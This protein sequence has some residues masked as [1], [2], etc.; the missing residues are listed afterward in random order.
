MKRQSAWCV[1]LRPLAAII[2]HTK[3]TKSDV[4]ESKRIQNPTPTQ[5]NVW[6]AHKRTILYVL[7][8][9]MAPCGIHAF[10]HAAAGHKEHN[11]FMWAPYTRKLIK[12]R[13]ERA[14]LESLFKGGK[15]PEF[16]RLRAP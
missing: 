1:F 3:C 2:A 15:I 8:S 14:P 5:N 7:T 16:F 13:T 10:T 6:Y 9:H 12:K 11:Y 4:E